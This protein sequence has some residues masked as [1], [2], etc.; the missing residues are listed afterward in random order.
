MFL[1][2]INAYDIIYLCETHCSKGM[3]IMVDGYKAYDN[4]CQVSKIEKPR[5]GAILYVKKN[6]SKHIVDANVKVND[7][8]VLHM[9]NHTVLCG[10]YI[11]PQT[12]HILVISLNF[13]TR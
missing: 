1:S 6:I 8:I 3:K 9:N 2:F 11:P 12:V 4:P 5:G 13:S 7:T 10:I